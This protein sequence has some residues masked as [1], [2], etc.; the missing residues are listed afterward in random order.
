MTNSL[1]EADEALNTNT[2]RYYNEHTS[3]KNSYR[4]I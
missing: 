3:N 1:Y 2:K 4:K